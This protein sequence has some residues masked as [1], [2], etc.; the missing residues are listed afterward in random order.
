MFA[1]G[2]TEKYKPGFRRILG[3]T[4]QDCIAKNVGSA[5]NTRHVN[6]AHLR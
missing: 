3:I 6:S 1:D 5:G 4:W 2:M